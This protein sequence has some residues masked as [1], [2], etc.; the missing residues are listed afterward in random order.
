MTQAGNGYFDRLAEGLSPEQRS[1]FFQALHEA[2]IT[3]HRDLE[4]ARLLR[5][6]QLYKAYYESIPVSRA[7]SR[8]RYR[9]PEAGDCR[10]QRR[11]YP[12]GRRCFQDCRGGPR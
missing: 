4:F 9:P 8:R 3:A 5:V 12:T 2:G 1:D 10:A 7:D 6:L 11:C